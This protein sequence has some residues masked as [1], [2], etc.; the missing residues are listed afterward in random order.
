MEVLTDK[1]NCGTV[2]M[3]RK[4]KLYHQSDIASKKGQLTLLRCSNVVDGGP[5]LDFQAAYSSLPKELAFEYLAKL[6]V[7]IFIDD[8]GGQYKKGS[9]LLPRFHKGASRRGQ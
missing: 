4:R 1:P 7:D 9:T 8:Y 2:V 5:F 6:L 3:Q